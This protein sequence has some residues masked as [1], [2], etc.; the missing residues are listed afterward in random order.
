MHASCAVIPC[1]P[2]GTKA[3]VIQ[4]VDKVKPAAAN[5]FNVS[6]GSC[7]AACFRHAVE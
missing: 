6:A 2:G 1:L 7:F 3:Q 4:L 5:S